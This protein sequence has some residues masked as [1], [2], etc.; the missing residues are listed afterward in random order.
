MNKIPIPNASAIEREVISQLVQSLD[1]KGVNCE[2][3]EK[4]IDERVAA[5]YEL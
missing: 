2:T 4:E 3:W 5:L 1:A